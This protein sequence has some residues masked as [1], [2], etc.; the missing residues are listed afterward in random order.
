MKKIFSRIVLPLLAF[1]MILSPVSETY[2]A[3]IFNSTVYDG[4]TVPTEACQSAY[5]YIK[6]RINVKN[7]RGAVLFKV[8]QQVNGVWEKPFY[9]SPTQWTYFNTP[10]DSRITNYKYKQRLLLYGVNTS[11][12][13]VDCYGSN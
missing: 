13:S 12:V 9:A 5:P 3:A 4:K 11:S 10:W 2:A 8:Q 1:V 7:I 6:Y